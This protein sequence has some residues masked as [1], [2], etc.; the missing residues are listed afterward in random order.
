[1]GG[2]EVEENNQRKRWA[3]WMHVANPIYVAVLTA[4]ISTLVGLYV[5]PLLQNNV[6]NEVRDVIEQ[7]A[8][9]V[10][11]GRIDEVIQ[12]YAEDAFVKD[13]KCGDKDLEE[14]WMGLQQ[15]RK[16]YAGIEQFIYLKHDAITITL[17][18][19]GEYASAFA[20]T[21][22]EYLDNGQA[23]KI[24]GGEKWALKKIDGEWKIVSF[25]YNLY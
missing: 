4:I 8:S 19:D 22:G 12:L 15:I 6:E 10:L 14:V 24:S 18:T 2:K 13:A 1:M 17:G 9:L 16:R 23:I 20:D 11:A 5:V 3:W 25:T 7:E 21:Q